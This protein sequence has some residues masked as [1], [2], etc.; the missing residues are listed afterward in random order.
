MKLCSV[1]ILAGSLLVALTA[2]CN[3]VGTPTAQTVGVAVIDLDQVARELGSDKQI[4]AAIKQRQDALNKKLV[5]LANSYVEQLNQHRE[6]AENKP[7]VSA[8]SLAQYEQK[9]NQNLGA[10]KRQAQVN[11]TQHRKQLVAQFRQ[12]VR[13]AARAVANER[14]LGVILTKQ[15]G[16]MFDCSRECDITAAVVM[17]LKQ[18]ASTQPPEVA[19]TPADETSQR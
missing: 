1:S 4:G 5:G 18:S 13:P 3:Q 2:G 12:A 8:V 14:G 9:A 17:R 19:T 7:E 15:E 6:Q 16:M 10:A 11:L